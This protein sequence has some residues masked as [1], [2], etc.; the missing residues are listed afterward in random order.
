EYVELS[1]YEQSGFAEATEAPSPSEAPLDLGEGE[2]MKEVST[3]IEGLAEGTSYRYRLVAT[4]RC[5]PAPAPL[6]E[7]VSEEST[8]TTFVTIG[9]GEGCPNDAFRA[10]GRGEFLPDCRAYEM[11]SPVDKN[12]GDIEPPPT[13]SSFPAGL[14]QAA[15]DGESIT[16]SSYKAFGEVAS[17]PFTNQ[18]L[19]RRSGA[20]GWTTEAIAPPREKPSLMTYKSPQLDRQY[21]AFSPDLC[22]G[23]LVQDAR[24]VLAPG[25]IEG[26][27]GLYRRDNCGAAAY[28]TLTLLEPPATAPP[29]LPPSK[30]IPE[31]QGTS[32]DGTVAV[33]ALHDNLTADAPAQP[34]ACV[35]ETNP[36]AEA[37]D[38]RLYEARAGEV[39]FVCILPDGTPYGGPCEAGTPL[40]E[41]GTGRSAS[42]FNAVSDDGSRIFWSASEEGPGKLYVRI[43]GSQ[44]SAKT[45]EVSSSTAAQFWAA[46]ADGSKAIYSVGEQL[47][48]FDVDAE[49]STL[50]AD[51]LVGVA[52]AGE[53]AS[54]V[55]FASDEVLS[56]E[57]ENSAGDKAQAGRPNLYLYE[58]GEG[59]RFVGTL[60]ESD[61]QTA[62]QTSSP[63][64]R[65]PAGRL[66]R[67]SS[68]GEQIVFM[69]SARLTGYDNTDA[70]TGE[71]T[72]EVFLYDAGADEGAGRVLCPSCNPSGARPE[73]RQLTQKLLHL[74]WAAARIPTY[75]SQLYGAR[76]LSEDGNRLYF[77]S[78]ESLVSTD[79]NE[80]EDV[81]Q[82][83]AP[84]TG[85]CTA[86]DPTY[87]EVSGGCLDLI[88]TGKHPYG[89]ELTDISADG[90]DVFFKTGQSILAQDPG[91]IDIYDARV[92]GGFPPLPPK[93]VICEGEACQS[94]RPTPEAVSP[95]TR[96]PAPPDPTWPKKCRKGLREVK[97]N[98]KIHCIKPKPCRKGTHKVKRNG[99]VRCVKNSRNGG[100]RTAR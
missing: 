47:F 21:K 16:Y 63:L 69:S 88:S 97:R 75:Q 73:G 59:S 24:P 53:D 25:G 45:V 8:F 85:T 15:L 99:K 17:A 87:H 33:F 70:V 58:A 84:G 9:P 60:E 7:F 11:V 26:F 80:A 30:F 28:E 35:E 6:C 93:P 2:A 40:G 27:P 92:G 20:S 77:N 5:K 57:E 94:P 81:Y 19:T 48:E 4:N 62:L 49:T 61:L 23:W 90:N 82:W 100:R 12:G 89:S 38:A 55:Y 54:R 44:P 13:L 67:V 74:R 91:K 72:M 32:A 98:G 78:F 18:Y 31:L 34:T 37:C 79:V 42:L 64:A 83:E 96:A 39:N 51:G 71:P 76:V 86:D 1:K 46:A 36:S 56:G 41:T 10:A 52:G 22:D 50:I 29:N 95:G 14:D 3:Q 65:S 68:D 66:S 43:D